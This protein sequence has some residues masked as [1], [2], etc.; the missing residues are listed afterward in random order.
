MKFFH[1][2]TVGDINKDILKLKQEIREAEERVQAVIK[3]HLKAGCETFPEILEL[4]KELGC[5]FGYVLD[6]LGPYKNDCL[7]S[8]LMKM[9]ASSGV[10]GLILKLVDVGLL[11]QNFYYTNTFGGW[12]ES[13]G[14][15]DK[16]KEY[17]C[18]NGFWACPIKG[19]EI[20]KE[21][22]DD[23]LYP[24]FSTTTKYNTIWKKLSEGI[25]NLL[26][27]Q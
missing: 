16:V 7:W 4:S 25:D 15:A 26:V 20:T 27:F 12:D 23:N 19:E 3:D 8:S 6:V 21:E 2:K 18:E 10:D 5:H 11:Y 14:N 1:K 13:I 9:E 17:D 24:L 22:F